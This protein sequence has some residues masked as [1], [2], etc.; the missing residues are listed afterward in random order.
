M[1]RLRLAL[2]AFS[3]SLITCLDGVG[4]RHVLALLGSAIPAGTGLMIHAGLGI[5]PDH[6]RI[7]C[8]RSFLDGV[9]AEEGVL[10]GSPAV[11]ARPGA[12]VGAVAAVVETGMFVLLFFVGGEPSAL[13][14]PAGLFAFAS[15]LA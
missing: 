7:F 15:A 6:A 2:L 3:R 14:F 5:Y 4:L 11:G 12:G 1:E 8:L 13:F 9:A 10:A